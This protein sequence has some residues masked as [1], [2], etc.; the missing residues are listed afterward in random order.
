[1][2]LFSN[3]TKTILWYIFAV[4]FLL[5]SVVLMTVYDELNWQRVLGLIAIAIWL[6]SWRF[7][8]K[9]FRKLTAVTLLLFT[10][11]VVNL[12]G[13]QTTWIDL[14]ADAE[15]TFGMFGI[16]AT[17]QFIPFLVLVIF[18]FVNA[19]VIIDRIKDTLFTSSTDNEKSHEQIIESFKAKYRGKSTD[20][21]E[22]IAKSAGT[23][24]EN[25]IEAANKVLAE[26]RTT[27]V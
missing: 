13:F 8:P 18:S 5:Y 27:G 14:Y 26:R 17:V 24:D 16:K 2:A 22:R 3:S 4:L 12:S 9:Y 21:L 10:F 19:G 25:A 20:E 1:M 11:R 6:G 23:F 7:F 15:V